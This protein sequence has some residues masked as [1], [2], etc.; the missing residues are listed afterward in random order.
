METESITVT[1][2][3]FLAVFIFIGTWLLGVGCSALNIYYYSFFNLTFSVGVFLYCAFFYFFPLFCYFLMYKQDAIS[4]KREILFDQ[5]RLV[6]V[7]RILLSLITAIVL[8]NLIKHGFPPALSFWGQETK[9][10]VEYGSLKQVLYAVL[11]V[12]MCFSVLAK[13]YS[14]LILC[15][16]V[17]FLFVARGP[18][19]TGVSSVLIFSFLLGRIKLRT[20]IL[21]FII[22]MLLNSVVGEMRTGKALFLDYM[23]IR[24]EKSDWDMSVLWFVSYVATPFSNMMWIIHDGLIGPFGQSLITLLPGSGR[25]GIID[26][27]SYPYKIIDGAHGYLTPIFNDYGLVGVAFFNL[28]L[29]VSFCIIHR[30]GSV[31]LYSYFLGLLVFIFFYNAFLQLVTLLSV[32][33][34]QFGLKYITDREVVN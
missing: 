16:F 23:N 24:L 3:I 31:V 28:I 21:I 2:S 15:M 5:S 26:D 1:Q 12:V 32:L 4:Y 6:Y 33:F 19:L 13:K 29:G 10:Y 30:K 8:F 14:Y 22:S 25:D 11:P 34:L 7:L 18:F 20:I 9:N 17:Y 27:V